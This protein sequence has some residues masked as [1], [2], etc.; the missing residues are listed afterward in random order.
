MHIAC[1]E[2]SRFSDYL[3]LPQSNSEECYRV[4]VSEEDTGCVLR[5]LRS[6]ARFFL[7]GLFSS[8]CMLS[9]ICSGSAS[10]ID[11]TLPVVE[12]AAST[13]DPATVVD[14]DVDE[15]ICIGVLALR[16]S[17][18]CLQQWG[19]TADY[20]TG[21]LPGY[22]FSIVPLG[23]DEVH[24]AVEYGEIDFVLANSSFYVNLEVRYGVMRIATLNN[25]QVNGIAHKVFAGV[26]FCR[27]DRDDIQDVEDLKNKTFMAVD[28]QSLG[29]WH[30][31][32]RELQQYGIDP[33][34]DF[35][36]LSFGGT[37]DAVVY[38]VLAEDVDAGTVRSHIL[39]RMALEGKIQLDSIKVLT[40]HHDCNDEVRYL[41]STRHYPEWPFAK[42][43]ATTNQL[44][45]QVAIALIGMPANSQAAK[46]AICA[47]W[48]IPQN[49]QPVREL[50]MALRL[51]P[52]EDYGKVTLREVLNKYRFWLLGLF[53]LISII[54]LFTIRSARLKSELE[55]SIRTE[56][57]RAR[58]QS[59]IQTIIDSLPTAVMVVE[60]D[61]RIVRDVN[62]AATEMI[63]LHRDK[64]TGKIC[65]EFI[66]PAAE[67]YCPI[68]DLGQTVDHSERVLLTAHCGEIPILKT[69]VQI[70]LDGKKCLLES[71]IDITSLKEAE[72]TLQ[73]AHDR[74]EKMVA[75]R[76]AD[77]EEANLHLQELDKLKS[78]F[79]ASMS[80]ELRTPLNSIIGFS[81][82]L[83]QGLSGE[84]NSEQNDSL[85]R[86]YRSGN[87]LL[88]LISDVIDISKIEAGRIDVFYEHFML[89]DVV[90]EAV[91][92][93]RP[94]VDAKNLS[95]EL[96]GDT[97]PEMNTD[98]KRLLQ[99]L[100]NLLSNAVKYTEHGKVDFSVAVTGDMVEFLVKDTGIG[101]FEDDMS[102]LF[103]PFERLDTHL[104]VKAGGTGLGLYLTKKIA[105]DLLHGSLSVESTVDEGSTFG[106]KIP[107]DV[108][109]YLSEEKN[110]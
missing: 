82:L 37:H 68:L 98:R 8:V 3:K 21:S 1:I 39:E 25:L 48:T 20:L 61:T 81:G 24:R 26:L 110:G 62:P 6:T 67:G 31:V 18:Q 35:A 91:E 87:H 109:D 5:F 44:A 71:F 89:K 74:L 27:A 103:E 15:H 84:L 65:H 12:E 4:T 40:F 60:A 72:N 13:V 53:L 56:K 45:E 55:Q 36:E 14:E 9:I 50:L 29:G 100:L 97:W 2:Q 43:P 105:E 10:A 101:I 104:R 95:L 66:C 78:M 54:I 16:G 11:E 46:D 33:H 52:Y 76:T 34:R 30:M 7:S 32:W 17:A 96:A 75:E 83:L 107:L 58:S 69:V 90:D 41:H 93:I 49:Y 85:N 70:V 22:T 86:I 47:G 51:S 19:A 99:C 64:I 42:C 80:H 88:E 63:G 73:Q 38:A 59:L 28:E 77:L 23:F 92:T 108:T 57:E 94:Q 102:K 79:I 106:M